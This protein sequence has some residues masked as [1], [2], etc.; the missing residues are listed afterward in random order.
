MLPLLASLL[1]SS[2]VG[3]AV[4]G[5]QAVV[6]SG[7]VE[8]LVAPLGIATL[9]PR[10]SWQFS[11]DA[12]NLTQTAF[13][14]HVDTASDFSGGGGSCTS[15]K[16]LSSV[17]SL[18]E[19]SPTS[20]G[21]S[22]Q[23]QPGRVYWW[24]LTATL[25]D[26]SSAM[27]AVM[28][29]QRFSTGLQTRGDW[30]A[31]AVFLGLP[32]TSPLPPD[33]AQVLCPW[34]RSESFTVTKTAIDSINA[35]TTSALLS[36]ASIGW[37]EVY[38]NG[39]RLE[40]SSVLI[41]SVSDMHR[42]VLSHQYDT[43]GALQL[44]SNT[45]AF[46]AAPGWSQLTWPDS[47][48]KMP[49]TDFNISDAPLVMGQLSLCPS[50]GHDCSLLVATT[51]TGGW[52]ARPS[53]IE[54]TGRWQWADYGGEKVDW[55]QNVANWSTAES[56]SGW[57]S[58]VAVPVDKAVTPESLEPMAPVETLH[59]TG[60]AKCSA[61]PAAGSCY[62]VSF[63]RLFNGFFS[64]SSLPGLQPG[65]SVTFTYSANCVSP[66]P[67]AMPY[68]PCAPPTAGTGV[69][70][71][72]ATEWNAIDSMVAGAG[73]TSFA[74]K[75]N[76]HTYQFVTIESNGTLSLNAADVAN[77]VGTRITNRQMRVGSFTSSSDVL[78]Q[79]YEAFAQ[80]YEGLT[81]S[82]MQVDCTN[83]ERLG[84]GGDAHS[85]IE[86]AM[87]SYTS[88]AL[89]ALCSSDTQVHGTITC[90]ETEADPKRFFEVSFQ[91]IFLS[92]VMERSYSIRSYC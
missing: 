60:I 91:S 31:S 48:W 8:H 73:S 24:K 39:Q 90:V 66:C 70:T 63:P 18:V 22:L 49:G 88:H 58:A 20:G 13:E 79:V 29:P 16:V 12:R 53:T 10:F 6:V 65:Q 64:A 38:L 7:T 33:G 17:A 71:A 55:T 34:F 37:H 59:A 85:R 75:F 52:K 15:G 21:G 35:G 43:Q 51:A 77:F 28:A 67:A 81:V 9:R 30:H 2:F 32:Q 84:Y 62:V 72:A 46:W 41:P 68:M 36:V 80:T 74:N 57:L 89:C 44:G 78:N 25:S 19:C 56:T 45:L 50:S 76:W 27:E 42:R 11:T 5:I 54:H 3:V 26:G 14:L 87:D 1:L 47:G 82:G 86:F 92:I 23:L 83:R 61:Q 4:A 69:C 40:Q